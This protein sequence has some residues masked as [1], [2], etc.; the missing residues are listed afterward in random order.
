MHRAPV[1]GGPFRP[2]PERPLLSI[3]DVRHTAIASPPDAP[4][5]T[6]HTARATPRAHPA[7]RPLRRP[8]RQPVLRAIQLPADGRGRI[9]I[10]V[11]IRRHLDR[12]AETRSRRRRVQPDRKRLIPDPAQAEAPRCTGRRTRATGSERGRP[13][14]RA[15][16]ASPSPAGAPP[17]P[18]FHLSRLGAE[19]VSLSA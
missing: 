12:L 5:P 4:S 19:R 1:P 14:R 7:D 13:P 3:A 10:P 6:R 16:S 18:R 17:P 11:V 15:T 9:R 8:C 2:I